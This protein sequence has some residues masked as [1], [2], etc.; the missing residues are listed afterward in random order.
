M[1]Q[2][3]T[4]CVYN[5]H[6]KRRSYKVFTPNPYYLEHVQRLHV[7]EKYV[8][9]IDKRITDVNMAVGDKLWITWKGKVE[10]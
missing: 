4:K 1:K 2:R 5:Q 6:Q 7:V 3:R 10:D 9:E 8:M